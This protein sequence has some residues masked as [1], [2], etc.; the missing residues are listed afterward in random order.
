MKKKLYKPSDI[1]LV[2]FPFSDLSKNKVRPAVVLAH[3]KED[4]T[5][6]FITSVKPSSSYFL[7][8]KPSGENNLKPLSYIRYSKIASLDGKIVLGKIG[9]LE[10]LQYVSLLTKLQNYLGLNVLP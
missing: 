9:S 3:D 10:A 8:V 4:Y 5:L 2:P 6:V 7:E 1:I